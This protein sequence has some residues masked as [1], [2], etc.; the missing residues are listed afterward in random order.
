MIGFKSKW[1]AN[2]KHALKEGQLSLRACFLF[3]KNPFTFLFYELKYHFLT[4]SDQYNV[5]GIKF[6]HP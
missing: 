4:T 3:W 1:K 5:F 2:K 6:L